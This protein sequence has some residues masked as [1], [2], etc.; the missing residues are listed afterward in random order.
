MIEE[1]DKKIAKYC[2]ERALEYGASAARVSLN[3]SVSDSVA[4]L[5]G[6]VDKVTHCADKSLYIYVFAD[7]RYGTFSTNASDPEQLDGFVKKAVEMVKIL[8]PDEYRQL[9]AIERTANDATRGDEMGLLDELYEELTPELRRKT[10]CAASHYARFDCDYKI[11]TEECEYSDGIDDN[12]LIDSNGFEGRH[13]ET[14]YTFCAEI[15][16][17]DKEGNK[18]SGYHWVAS[19]FLKSFNCSDCADIALEK[20]V[21]QIGPKPV[22]SGR[23]CMIVDRSVGSR[24]LSPVLRALDTELIQ[25]K[26][27][28]LPD[29]EGKV[30]FSENLTIMDMA[31]TPGKTGSRMFDSEGVATV[32]RPIIENGKVCMNCTTTYIA[33]KTS[34][35]PTI[36]GFSRPVILPYIES[37]TLN[38]GGNTISLENILSLCQ[39]GIYVTGFN[40]GN[41]NPVTGDFSYGVEGFA[42]ENG[43][44]SYP[45]KEILIT[46]NMKE[47]WKNFRAAG[48]DARDCARWS[49]PT[50]AFDNVDFSA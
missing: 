10:A 50:L 46:G 31:R 47:L 29:A 44:I 27:S 48:S 28:F 30:I 34:A 9:P 22:Q 5:N 32:E 33:A 3:V 16:I 26:N 39:K 40:G 14:S 37:E 49:I 19:P 41:C 4:T 11:I 23:M 20:A 15:T 7:G 8:A 17:E 24:L 42:F 36:D 21:R 2:I 35:E 1:K 38:K 6:E 13:T 25:Q 43:Q 12:Y 45:V 18:Y